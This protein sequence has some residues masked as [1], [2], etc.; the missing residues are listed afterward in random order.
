MSLEYDKKLIP[1]AKELRKNMTP[2]ERHLWYDFLSTYPVRFQRQKV[3]AEYIADFYCHKARLVIEVDGSQHYEPESIV[4]DAERTAVFNSL[5]I[6][7]LRFSNGEVGT[8]FRAVCAKIA[9]TVSDKCA[10]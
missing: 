5:G 6:E 10:K 1:R 2:Q 4:Y 3:I 8:D 7:V 9:Y